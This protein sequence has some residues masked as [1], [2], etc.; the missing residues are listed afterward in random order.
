MRDTGAWRIKINTV[1]ASECLDLRVFGQIFRRRVLDVVI[2]GEDWLR[3]IC[4]HGRPDLLELW[5]YRT[6]VVMSHHVTR[7]NR[8]EIATP[9][10]RARSK[11][12]RVTPSN[13]LNKGQ[14]HIGFH[15]NKKRTHRLC[16]F[17]C[18]RKRFAPAILEKRSRSGALQNA[19]ACVK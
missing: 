18:W 2:D 11:S 7:A 17:C 12:I 16:Q 14:T 13:L 19:S 10:H 15:L 3:R 9:N 4:D 5:Y 6:R 8:D 1:F